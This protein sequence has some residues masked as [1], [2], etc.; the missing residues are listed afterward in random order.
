MKIKINNNFR[1]EFLTSCSVRALNSACISSIVDM[2]ELKSISIFT[3]RRPWT[4]RN[5][6]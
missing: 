2:L 6:T 3:P 1:C 4:W 5:W